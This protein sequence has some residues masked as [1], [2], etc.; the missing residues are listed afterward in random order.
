MQ[1][2]SITWSLV[3]PS[4]CAT[5]LLKVV[6]GEGSKTLRWSENEAKEGPRCWD[7]YAPTPP[8]RL[9]EALNKIGEEGVRLWLKIFP[10]NV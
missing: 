6:G 2:C 1:Q 10:P 7:I 8:E 3:K 5:L 4:K 9:S